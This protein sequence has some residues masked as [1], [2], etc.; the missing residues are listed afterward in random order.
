MQ[1]V[2]L[3]W[4]TRTAEWVRA[5]TQLPPGSGRTQLPHYKYLVLPGSQLTQSNMLKKKKKRLCWGQGQEKER[6]RN[7][8]R[9]NKGPLRYL[10]LNSH[11]KISP[12]FNNKEKHC[13]VGE[14]R[15]CSDASGYVFARSVSLVPCLS[16][17]VTH[18]AT[19]HMNGFTI[20]PQRFRNRGNRPKREGG[21]LLVQGKALPR[22]RC[23]S[24][25]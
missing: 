24:L 2:S 23:L 10:F 18:S 19:V 9:K 1:C 17:W 21:A 14:T 22:H 11:C 5:P 8:P 16:P 13:L 6:R 12:A 3:K 20:H 4:N 25:L 7:S 15:G